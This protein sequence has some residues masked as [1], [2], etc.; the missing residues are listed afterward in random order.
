MTPPT[1]P[2]PAASP[3][4]WLAH[5]QSDLQLARLAST[6]AAILAEQ[7][8]F[9]AQQACEK[10]FKA[11]LLAKRIPFP[12]THDLEALLELAQGG[13]I[14]LPAAL[15]EIGAVSP[16]AVEARYPGQA[17]DITTSDVAEAIHL[18]EA[19]LRWAVE[20]VGR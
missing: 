8:C 13:G 7:V 19:V 10:A 6:Q 9:H 2:R 4:A 11:V 3:Q 18:A 15:K 20:L 1:K 14:T 16:Y 17:E 5:A 12:L